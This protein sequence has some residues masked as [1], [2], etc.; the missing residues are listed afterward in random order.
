M[1]GKQ[2]DNAMIERA[3]NIADARHRP[4]DAVPIWAGFR[5]VMLVALILV[6]LRIFQEF[7]GRSWA[8]L[9]TMILS[10]VVAF[11]DCRQ[12]WRLNAR[13]MKETLDHMRASDD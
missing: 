1:T 12:T 6:I 9:L 10:G 5:A 2:I 7:V 11:A 3:R 13:V 4:P 8:E